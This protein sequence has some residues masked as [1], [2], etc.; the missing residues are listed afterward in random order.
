MSWLKK[1]ESRRLTFPPWKALSAPLAQMP[2]FIRRRLIWII[3]AAIL[4]LAMLLVSLSKRGSRI[5]KEVVDEGPSPRP[6]VLEWID[7]HYGHD[8]RTQ[9]NGLA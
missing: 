7:K 1:L 5:E 2:M 8:H 9:K 4:V 3:V 6:D